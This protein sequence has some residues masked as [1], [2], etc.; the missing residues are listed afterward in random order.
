[1]L[2]LSRIAFSFNGAVSIEYLENAAPERVK[3]LSQHL[4]V[5]SDEVKRN[6]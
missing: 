5:I 3:E 1:M 6:G 4:K 2:A